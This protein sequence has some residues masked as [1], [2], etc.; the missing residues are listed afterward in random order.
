MNKGKKL[1]EGKTK[2]FIKQMKKG[3]LFN[4][5]KMMQQPIML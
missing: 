2:S 1:Y 3:W 4:I 5:L